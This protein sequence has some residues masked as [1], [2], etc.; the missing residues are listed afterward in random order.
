[1]SHV[2]GAQGFQV[3]TDDFP[4]VDRIFAACMDVEAFAK[5]APL[6]QPGA[7]G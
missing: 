6:R 7:P 1:M 5:A 2:T 3:T 4:T